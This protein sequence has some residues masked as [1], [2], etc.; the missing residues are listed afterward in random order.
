MESKADS[1]YDIDKENRDE[2]E[3]R[4][5][6]SCL[7]YHGECID[8]LNERRRELINRMGTNKK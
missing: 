6:D 1:H 4:V 5:I 2:H 3:L 7:K 8:G